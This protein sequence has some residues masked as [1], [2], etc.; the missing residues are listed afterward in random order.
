MTDSVRGLVFGTFSQYLIK[1][2][3]IYLQKYAK[4]EIILENLNFPFIS[5]TNFRTHNIFI[6]N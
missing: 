1:F 2:T 4:L 6:M 3:S 5:I